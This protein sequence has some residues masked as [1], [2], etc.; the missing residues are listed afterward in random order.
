MSIVNRENMNYRAI[1][2]IQNS[3]YCYA[4]NDNTVGLML[5]TSSEDKFEKITLIY[6]N[7]YDYYF[8]QKR[9]ELA[10][11]FSDG[12]FDYYTLML[13]LDDVRLVYVFELQYKEKIYYF[14]E[15]GL[16]DKY[17]FSL[18]FYNSFQFPYINRADVL[19]EV[20]WMKNARFYEIFTDRFNRGNKDKDDSYINLKWG[21][22]PTP[23]SFAGGDLQGIIDKLDYLASLGINAI[24]LTPIFKS[25]S[26]HKYDISDYYEIDEHF[27]D[28]ATFTSLVDAAHSKGIKIVLDAVFNHCSEKFERFQ[29][30]VIRGKKSPYHDWFIIN[31][32][33]PNSDNYECFGVCKYMPKFNTSNPEVQKYLL[34]IAT[35]WIKEFDIDGW[36]LDVS[37]EV[38]HDFW[39]AFRKVVKE[40]KKD[41][42]ILGEN[43]HDSADFLRGDQFDGIMNYALT[44]ACLDYFARGLFDATMF[45]DKLSELYVRNTSTVNNMML[46]LLDSHDTHRFYT[47]CKCNQDK[48]ICALAL[49]YLHTGSTCI[50]Y[51]TEIPLEGGYDP[52]CRRTMVWNRENAKLKSILVALGELKNRNEIKNGGIAYWAQGDLFIMERT[53]DK[54]VRLTINN[55]GCG[56]DYKP[57]GKVLLSHNYQNGVIDAV[58]FIIEEVSK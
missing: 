50:Y 18:A 6:G 42:I 20:E 51:G 35:Y 58:G 19:R 24:Y 44:K 29:D 2:H 56:I 11:S 53:A 32:D 36:R 14:S 23:K 7:K 1:L 16:S 57:I 25:I 4:V 9:E 5:R 3:Q 46:N 31:G 22:I 38:S 17:D 21:D 49:I 43:W 12:S 34:E 26:N 37:D 41:C 10:K 55:S 28:K 47:E 8:V 30:V 52:D 33:K 45:A 40:T 48:L 15:D 27:G 54:K 39:R 13:P